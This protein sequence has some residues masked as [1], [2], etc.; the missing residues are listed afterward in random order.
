MPE[1]TTIW[2]ALGQVA[3]D[4]LAGIPEAVVTFAPVFALLAL[5]GIGLGV[6]R[7]FGVRR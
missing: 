5:I 6:A 1:E 4:V 3:T 2:T 7:K